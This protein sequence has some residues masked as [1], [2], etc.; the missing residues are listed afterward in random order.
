MTPIL[1]HYPASLFSEKVRLA[2]GLRNL[3]WR[4]VVIS[5]IMPR[6]ELMPLTGGYRRTPVLQIGADIYCDTQC[7]LPR[8]AEMPS[9][10]EELYP[11]AGLEWPITRWADTQFF[12]AAVGVVFGSLPDGALSRAFLEDR[13]ALSGRPFDLEAM[14][15]AAP[16]ARDQWRSGAHWVERRLLATPEKPS[17]LLGERVSAADL[18]VYMVFWFV[19]RARSANSPTATGGAMGEATR[20]W[21]RRVAAIGHGSPRDLTSA[22]ALDEAAAATPLV[23]ER[24]VTASGFRAGQRVR[25]APD[26]Y[27]KVPVLGELVRADDE[28]ITLLRDDERAGVIAVHFPRVGFRL[29]PAQ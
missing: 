10:G 5:D 17:W 21:M 24:V 23:G 7:I 11:Y 12:Q 15:Q 25:V 2:L 6:P 28:G 26:D 16:H 8:L 1:H 29:Q 14:R 4:S 18:A 20:G 9:D 27:G 13:E 22:E 3:E 19:E